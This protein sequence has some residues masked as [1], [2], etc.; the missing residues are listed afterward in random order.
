MRIAMI[1]QKGIPA[2][3]GGV[4]RHVEELASR[5]VECGHDVTVY[6]RPHYDRRKARRPRPSHERMYYRG[7]RLVRVPSIA[8]KHL[9]AISHVALCTAHAVASRVDVVHYHAV[10]PALFSWIPRLFRQ[11]AVVTVHGQDAMR[12]KWGGF[13]SFVLRRGEWVAVHAP[14]AT[15]CVSETL[16]AKLS[17]RYRRR[18]DFVPNGVDLIEGSDESI[19]SELGVE[20]GKYILFASRLVPEKGCHYLIEAWE[21]AGRPLPLVM[22]GD[23]SFSPN[24]VEQIKSMPSGS[25]VVFP[26]NIYGA[27][28]ASL[29]R[30]ATLFVLP[31]DLEGL[32]IVLLEALGYGAP[33]LASDIPPNLEAMGGL[34]KTFAA[35]NVSDLR[36]KLCECLAAA[37]ELKR[38]A[39][40]EAPRITSSYD[41]DVVTRQTI[42][43]YMLAM[44]MVDNA[45]RSPRGR[46]K[47][48]S[49]L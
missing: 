4:E 27:R 2:T 3:Y 35:G 39:S 42:A 20:R 43:V 47:G 37:R 6:T 1:G 19:L 48:N 8:T 36:D 29:F 10:G 28:L 46:G 34:G 44:G 15:I 7:V 45:L 38:V 14:N 31:S 33:V 25:A 49:I 13:A 23:S 17:Q 41:W 11:K 40:L 24:Y 21:Q 30:N 12:P 18:V 16:T 9:D 22:A 32:P 5:L 26:G